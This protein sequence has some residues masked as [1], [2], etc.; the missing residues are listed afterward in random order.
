LSRL[1]GSAEIFL[2]LRSGVAKDLVGNAFTANT[3]HT[4]SASA[5]VLDTTSPKLLDFHL[6]T[7]SFHVALHFDEP[8]TIEGS[9]PT[10]ITLQSTET[11]GKDPT[12]TLSGEKGHHRRRLD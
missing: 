8:V 5:F 2:H 7:D 6:D 3:S 11:S 9:D 12:L 4:Y 10:V 1:Y